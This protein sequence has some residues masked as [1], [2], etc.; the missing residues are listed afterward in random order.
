MLMDAAQGR[1]NAENASTEE[2]EHTQKEN[3]VDLVT[4]TDKNV[5]LFIKNK[6]KERYPSHKYVSASLL[7]RRHNQTINHPKLH[8]RRILLRNLL[9]QLPNRQRTNMVCRPP[10]RNC[11]LHPPLSHLLRQH[12][13]PAQRQAPHRRHTRSLHKPALHLLRRSRCLLKRIHA[14]P[15]NPETQCTT[16]ACLCASRMRIRVRVGQG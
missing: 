6:I 11:E 10:R 8:R 7:P 3:E 4:E 14:T 5:E 2:K 16:H 9:P 13:L 15:S 1:I 12:R